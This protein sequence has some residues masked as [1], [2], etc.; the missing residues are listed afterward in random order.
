MVFAVYHI[1]KIAS[2]N[3]GTSVMRTIIYNI[4]HSTENDIQF[5]VVD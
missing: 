1:D 4:A 3:I 2:F 5:Y